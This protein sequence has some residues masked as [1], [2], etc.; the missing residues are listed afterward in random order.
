MNFNVITLKFPFVRKFS[1]TSAFRTVTAS[2][3]CLRVHVVYHNNY[4]NQKQKSL[5]I[6]SLWAAKIEKIG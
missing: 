1:A 5:L 4:V 3:R 2:N 6:R